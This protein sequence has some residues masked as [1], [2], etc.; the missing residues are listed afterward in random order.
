MQHSEVFDKTDKDRVHWCVF[1]LPR[2]LSFSHLHCFARSAK[3]RIHSFD[4][5]SLHWLSTKNDEILRLH[6]R[7]QKQLK[8]L[9]VLRINP[10]S[11]PPSI[12]A[13]KHLEC[14]GSLIFVQLRFSESIDWTK[15]SCWLYS[16]STLRKI[17]SC[18]N[19]GRRLGLF[20][21][22]AIYKNTIDA[23]M[24]QKV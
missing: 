9:S 18:E 4:N 20:T 11:A 7:L 19:T 14:L 5:C 1:N 23:C 24:V 12:A 8:F 6:Q 22:K 13:G 21:K 10:V 2:P 3:I 16:K 15:T 17:G